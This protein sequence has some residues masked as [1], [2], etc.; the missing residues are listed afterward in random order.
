MLG[1]TKFRPRREGEYEPEK[2]ADEFEGESM[3]KDIEVALSEWAVLYA[4]M[5]AVVASPL[6]LLGVG[7]AW[8]HWKGGIRG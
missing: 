7:T 3:G 4:E 5:V 6:V 2:A 1:E 8:L